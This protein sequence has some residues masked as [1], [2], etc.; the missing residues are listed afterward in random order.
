MPLQ[1]LTL[2]LI[3]LTGRMAHLCYSYNANRAIARLLNRAYSAWITR[4]LGSAGANVV[5]CRNAYLEGPQCIHIGQ[6]TRIESFSVLTCWETYR[7]ANHKPSI[8]IGENCSIGAFCHITAIHSI[9]FGNGVLTGKWVTVTD[10]AHGESSRTS[11]VE[12]PAYR[13]LHSG[14][15]VIIGDNVWIGDKATILPG[16]TIGSGA[17]VGANAVVTKSIPPYSIA[18][19][20]PARSRPAL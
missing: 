5:I 12:P 9:I 10:N 19:G 7:G 20:A 14:G 4:S 3:R 6:N 18:V 8:H 17:I 11:M 16:V 13:P 1:H 2:K 15:P